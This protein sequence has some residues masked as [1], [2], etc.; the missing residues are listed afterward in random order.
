MG[1]DYP[2]SGTESES[3]MGTDID[4][5]FKVTEAWPGPVMF[6]GREIASGALVGDALKALPDGNI[7]RRTFELSYGS[8]TVTWSSPI[9]DQTA[10]LYAVRGL[11]SYWDAVT[12]GR[13]TVNPDGSNAWDPS[14]DRDHGYLVTKMTLDKLEFFIEHLM[15]FE[16]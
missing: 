7:L 11:E 14:D 12:I 2:T 9:Y 8:D 5:S 13:N 6:A 1:G 16:P 4:A 10:V 3:N 15:M